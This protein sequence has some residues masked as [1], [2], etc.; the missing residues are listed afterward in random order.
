MKRPT[1]GAR[2]KSK[3]VEKVAMSS[4]EADSSQSEAR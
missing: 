4:E 3:R 1:S 2:K